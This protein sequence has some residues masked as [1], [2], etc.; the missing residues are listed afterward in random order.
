METTEKKANEKEYGTVEFGGKT[1]ILTQQ[2]YC[3]NYGTD[4]GVRYYAH[5]VAADDADDATYKVVWDTTEEW[6]NHQSGGEEH[7][8]EYDD[9]NNEIYPNGMSCNF[10]EDE[11]NACDWDKPVN[12]YEVD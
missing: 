7:P 2:A 10:C 11:S 9:D 4:G 1:Y 12:V 6:D 8:R 5:A 3:N